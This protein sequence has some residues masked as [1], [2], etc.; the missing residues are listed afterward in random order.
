M[1]I[2]R[3]P[4][5]NNPAIKHRTLCTK[6]KHRYR[7][8]KDFDIPERVKKCE[9]LPIEFVKDCKI[10]GYLKFDQTNIQYSKYKDKKYKWYQCKECLSLKKQ[11]L[12]KE[13]PEKHN[14]C[15]TNTRNKRI[16]KARKKNSEYYITCYM[17]LEEHNQMVLNQD[18]KCKI[19][20]KKETS[21]HKNGKTKRLSIDHNHISGKIRGLLCGKCNTALGL[22]KDSIRNLQSAIHYLLSYDD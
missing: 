19:C 7:K 21:E 6:H 1:R 16:D 12:Y 17:D 14:K 9:N 22:F 10:H 11:R 4:E 3:A 15:S 8:N 20:K 5:C 13:N 2:C 18:N